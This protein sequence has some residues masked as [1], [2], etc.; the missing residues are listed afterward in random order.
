MLV[1]TTYEKQHQATSYLVL[2]LLREFGFCAGCWRATGWHTTASANI[3]GNSNFGQTN[4]QAGFM[5]I[6]QIMLRFS[7]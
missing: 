1:S 6:T 4:L 3:F 2:R 5:R 7:F